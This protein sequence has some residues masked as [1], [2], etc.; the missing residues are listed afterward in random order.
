[1]TM[2]LT[3]SPQDER[4]LVS[5]RAARWPYRV[6]L[7]DSPSGLA[8][9][10]PSAMLEHG[11]DL[12]RFPDGASALVRLSAE[13]PA[14]VLVPTDIEGV[15]F[16]SFV[17]AVAAWSDVAIVIGLAAGPESHNLAYEALERGARG[18]LAM[19][20][21]PEQLAAAIQRIG[22][23]QIA[24]VS[25]LNYGPIVLDHASHRVLLA[26]TP[27][28]FSPKEFSLLE[29]LLHEAP[30]VVSIEEMNSVIGEPATRVNPVRVRKYVE[31]IRRTLESASSG[32]PSLIQNVRG[33]GYR[34]SV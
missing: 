4:G 28:H 27:L 14:A 11:V 2:A 24:A 20:F 8:L 25:T 23:R 30:R 34:L 31:K 32:Q 29:Y 3:A 13:D 26:G 5:A 16:L 19:P 7:V 12:H 21:S 18:L 15:D 33:L 6:L 22:L 9:G 10:S 1:L 17:R